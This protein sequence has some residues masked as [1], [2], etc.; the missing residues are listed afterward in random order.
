MP[1]VQDGGFYNVHAD[2]QGNL[3]LADQ[4]NGKLWRLDA[5][6]SGI[7]VYRVHEYPFDALPDATGG[8]WWLYGTSL[9]RLDSESA[10]IL[11]WDFSLYLSDYASFF[12]AAIDVSGKVWA[13]DGSV[14]RAYRFVPSSGQFCGYTLPTNATGSY[15]AVSGAA[16]WFGDFTNG[17]L[18]RI[19]SDLNTVTG[20]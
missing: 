5:S 13:T 14:N 6:D 11:K 15:P 19:D 3:W 1:L 4:H 18:I 8:V 7:K 16:L 12:G 20:W 9:N 17:Q 10:E 2:T